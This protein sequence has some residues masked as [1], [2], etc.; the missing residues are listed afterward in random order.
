MRGNGFFEWMAS[1]SESTPNSPDDSP[2]T[3]IVES[4]A[5][6]TIGGT[7]KLR[8]LPILDFTDVKNHSYL[9]A[10]MMELLP[11]DRDRAMTYFRH[12]HLGLGLFT[13]VSLSSGSPE[14][15]PRLTSPRV[16]ALARQQ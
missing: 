9:Q 11:Q 15:S 13:A 8:S 6:T 3:D 7:S 1:E 10:I 16:L 14:V 5:R 2:E 12:R 4:F